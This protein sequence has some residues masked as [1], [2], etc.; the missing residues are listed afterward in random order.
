[1][2][3]APFKMS[4]EYACEKDSKRSGKARETDSDGPGSRELLELI[5]RQGGSTHE[6]EDVSAVESHV[7]HQRP[8]AEDDDA[9][10]FAEESRHELIAGTSLRSAASIEGMF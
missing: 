7:A 1:M 6:R 8:R 3:G 9:D 4:L 5:R 2:S 10:E